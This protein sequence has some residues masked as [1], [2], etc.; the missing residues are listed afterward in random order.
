M[1]RNKKFLSIVFV[2]CLCLW[3]NNVSAKSGDETAPAWLK[4]ASSQ[5]NFNYEKDVPAVVLHN[6]Q[7]AVLSSDGVLTVT[8]NHAVRLLTRD[9]KYFADAAA[10]YLQSAS[11]V[12]EMRAWLIRPDGTTK[13]YG[14]DQ[15]ID[16]ILDPDDIYNEYRAKTVDASDDADIG[17]VFAYQSI[18][19]ERPL[20]TQDRWEFQGR[21]PTLFSRY[22]LTLPSGWQAASVTFNNAEIKPQISGTS[23]VWE[24][25]DLKPIPP[26][27]DSPRPHTLAPRIMVNY[28]PTGAAA[29]AKVFN[30]WQE[31][32]RWGSEL[33]ESSVTLD[34]AIAAKARELTANAKTELEKIRA[35]AVYV[36][37][38]RYISID[39]GVAKGNGYKPRPANLVLQRGYGDCKDKAN[40][41]RAMLRALK[42]EAYPVFIFSGDPTFVREE[43]ASP[44]QFNHCIIAVR[45]SAETTAPTVVTHEKLGR[46]L[47]FDATDPYT[48]LGD[49]PDHEQGSFALVA[50][51]AEGGL[52]KM[53]I[54]PP[55]A[56]RQE[57]IAEGTLAPDG[58]LQAIIKEQTYGQTAKYYRGMFRELSAADYRTR[59]EGWLTERV[60]G[61]KLTKFTPNDRAAEGRFDLDMEFSAAG[62]AQV[63]GGRLMVF[64]PGFVGRLDQFTVL[65]KP[66]AHPILLDSSAYSETI[67]VK[68]PD[69]FV[70]D[71]I[72]EGDKAETP[73]G[74]YSVNYEIKDGFL[75]LTRSLSI[76]RTTLPATQYETVK[77]FFAHVR[78]AEVAPVVLVKK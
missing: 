49:L 75:L 57:R 45:I 12:R 66:R 8:T 64:K 18:V 26:E 51:G 9:G 41:M 3:A 11:K 5:K 20:F 67:R 39:I 33:H 69:G 73:F 32:S 30:S 34:D 42:I 15:I 1:I 31:V 28:F 77:N 68:L 14:K 13:F 29:A 47:I 46:L 71:E 4:Q 27:P 16:R 2:V 62:Y 7:T 76:N 17:A 78:A 25:R 58:S 35:L 74:K 65:D 23:Y 48:L 50:A 21:L 59:N 56:N 60:T 55:D 37:N 24:M 63:M 43:W 19:E 44:S 72:P 10:V 36:Q 38:L 22:Q 6:E 53:P 70:V 52:M 40:L 61:A 54:L